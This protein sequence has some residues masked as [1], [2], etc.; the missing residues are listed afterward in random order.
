MNKAMP[1]GGFRVGFCLFPLG[2]SLG[3]KREGRA[4]A[5][6]NYV[7]WSNPQQTI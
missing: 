4:A 3:V 1:L 5:Q 6:R 7:V 2:G